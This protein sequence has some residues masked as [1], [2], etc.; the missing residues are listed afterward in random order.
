MAKY[1]EDTF[2]SVGFKNWRKAIEKCQRHEKSAAHT[3]SRTNLISRQKADDV[4]A[5]LNRQLLENQLL[6]QKALLK[7]VSSLQF[8]AKQGLAIRGKESTDG[9]FKAL[10]QLRA[11]DDK[12]LESWIDKK[13]SY[14]SGT[15]QNEILQLMSHKILRNIC[16]RINGI[17]SITENDTED[18]AQDDPEDD[19]PA[20][21]RRIYAVIMD[22]TQDCTGKEQESLCIRYVDNKFDVKEEFLG[23]Y[24]MSSTTGASL[25]NML[26]DALTRFQLPLENLRAQTYDGASN[27]S[28]KY[29][30]CQA[31]V[32][33][34]QLLAAYTHCGAHVTHLVVSKA[35]QSAPYIRDAL[36]HLQ[37]LGKFYKGS[38]KFKNLYLNLHDEDTECPSPSQLK[39]ICPTRWLTRSASIMAFLDNYEDVMEALTVASRDFGTKAASRAAGLRKC[40]ESNKCILG[41]TAVLPIIQ[42]LEKFNRALQGSGVNV[43]GMIEAADKVKKELQRNRSEKVFKEHFVEAQ[44]KGPILVRL[45]RHHSRYESADREEELSQTTEQIYRTEYFKVIDSAITNMDDYFTSTDLEEQGRLASMLLS[46]EYHQDLVDK[47]P[48]LSHNLR[49]ELSFFRSQFKA[50]SVEEYRQIFK[51]M[52]PAVRRMFGEV[53]SLLRLL[54]VSPASSTEAE[55]SFSTLRRLKTWLRNTMT[56]KRLNH[57]MVCHIHQEELA[58]VNIQDIAEEFVNHSDSRRFVF[59]RFR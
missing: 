43:S 27:M 37:E 34:I 54:L 45:R 22:G 46:G 48:E 41:L 56:Q 28:G 26:K 52:E 19:A 13:Q 44:K 30:G 49:N 24:E 53:E 50:S 23:L 29:N 32:K 31:E 39:P 42:C 10:L 17:D 47:Y 3:I 16:D 20:Q 38:G 9:N 18:D 2:V 14:T 25:C 11:S 5:Q 51:A 8:L 36:D 4:N 6:A 58:E 59:G 40:L 35:V 33:K 55:R 7:I 57:V 1:K 21:S 12:N 15:I